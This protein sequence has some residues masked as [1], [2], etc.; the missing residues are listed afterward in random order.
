M[1]GDV[2]R[3]K[4]K[5]IYSKKRKLTAN[6]R[7]SGDDGIMISKTKNWFCPACGTIMEFWKEDAYGDLIYSCTNQYCWKSKDWAGTFDI[8]MAKLIKQHQTYGDRYYR[9]YMGNYYPR[10][11]A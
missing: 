3:F 1:G 7:K 6:N 8:K 9:G 11:V 10:K 2:V 4:A 5:G